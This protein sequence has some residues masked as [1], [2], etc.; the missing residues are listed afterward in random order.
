MPGFA[1]S[2]PELVERFA[3]ITA[4]LAGVER[5]LTFGYPCLYV[6]GNM[7]SGLHESRWFVRLGRAEADE[8]LT[9]DGAGPFEVM[10][11]RPMAGYVVLPEAIV[12]DDQAARSWVERAIAFG[13]TLPSK[14]AKTARRT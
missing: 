5:R 1:K 2:P 6:G 7:V 10:P 12:T 11:G 8:L 4:D 14:A 13:R 3:A 9:Q